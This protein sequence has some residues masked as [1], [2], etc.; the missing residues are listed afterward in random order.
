MRPQERFGTG[1][2]APGALLAS[3][4]LAVAGT[5]PERGIAQQQPQTLQDAL[6]AGPFV[7][8]VRHNDGSRSVTARDESTK[9]MVITTYDP[10]GNLQLRRVYQLDRY[11]KPVTFF[12]YDGTGRPLMR[13]EYEYDNRER[14]VAERLFELPSGEPIRTVA[15]NYDAAG[16]RLSPQYMHQGSLPPQVL[17]WLNPDEN[18]G[19]ND[20]VAQQKEKP[21]NFRPSIFGKRNER[22]NEPNAA[23]SSSRTREKKKDEG[24]V[25][26]FRGLF[27]RSKK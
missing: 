23:R 24:G 27:D 18:S 25:G 4:L 8:M 7:R 3:G 5:L 22:S 12:V 13:G 17:R 2:R 16:N 20:E 1:A 19:R 9:E 6:A 11:G 15:Q 10:D 26:F 14:V 21:R